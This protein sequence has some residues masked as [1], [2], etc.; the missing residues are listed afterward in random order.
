M[1]KI[2]MIIVN[3]FIKDIWKKVQSNEKDI[4]THH[5]AKEADERL[6]SMQEIISLID[7]ND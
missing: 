5:R 2:L 7:T 6:M 1:A 4:L 3:I